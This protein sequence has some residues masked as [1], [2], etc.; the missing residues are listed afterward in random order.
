[1]AP[2]F[3][4]EYRHLDITASRISAT[5]H[6]RGIDHVFCGGFAA[7]LI[8]SKRVTTVI[9]FPTFSK[10]DVMLTYGQDIDLITEID[11]A[12]AFVSMPEFN[13]ISISPL[14]LHLLRR[15][16]LGGFHVS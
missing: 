3:P 12:S 5:L 7:G 1:M 8:G 6:E 2:P 14:A 4:L 9:S 15:D 11:P 10:T 16:S 13:R